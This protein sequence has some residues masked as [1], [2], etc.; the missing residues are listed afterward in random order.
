MDSAAQPPTPEDRGYP[1]TAAE[2]KE[3]SRGPRI[4]LRALLLGAL[5]IAAIFYGIDIAVKSQLP[6]VVLGAFVVWLFANV[7]LKRLWP[8]VALRRGELLTIFGMLWVAGT[9]SGSGWMAYWALILAAPAYFDSAENQWAETLFDFLP[10]HVFPETSGRVIDAFWLG[11]PQGA[12][13]PWDGW[14]GATMQWLSVSVALVAFGFCL[15]VLFQRQWEDQE[16]LA[17]PM[18]QLP[19]ELTRGVDGPG[20]MPEIFRTRLFWVGFAAAFLP[21]LYSICTYFTP[22]VP[23]LEF[24][25]Q[26]YDLELGD[27][28]PILW[29]RFLPLLMIMMYLCPLDI[30]GS[31]VAFYFFAVMKGAAMHRVGFSLGSAGHPM[32]WEKILQMESY[33]AMFFVVAWSFWLARGHLRRV[34]RQVRTGE[35]DRDEVWR[36]R[37][38]LAGLVVSG[39]YVVGWMVGLGMSLPL[40]AGVFLLTALIYFLI[41][42]LVAAT[43]FTYLLPDWD[44]M[45]GKDFILEL[46]GTV[47]LS[48]Q[49]L[50]AFSVVASHAFFGNFRVSAWPAIPHILK[51]FSMRVQPWKVAAA[52]LLAFVVGFFAAAVAALTDGYGGGM[53]RSVGAG[54]AAFDYMVELIENPRI[55][56]PERWAVWLLGFFEAMGLALLRAHFHWFPL[57]PIGLA[58]QYTPSPQRY[59][60][61]LALVWL[62]KF[63]LLRFGGVRSYNKGKLF[64]YGLGIGYVIGAMLS[65]LVD[66]VWFPLDPHTVHTW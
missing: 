43:G 9:I 22:G 56:H 10:W 26:V 6:L 30:L 46:V 40:A 53:L 36:Y 35:G 51:I 19:L 14:L 29:V 50:V 47:R 60:A 63:T 48:S 66:Y 32:G 62:A 7:A 57:H 2:A 64:F 54:I 15:I 1:E 42:K 4:T 31:L 59:W 52:V 33:G 28:F 25:W 21:I 16:R 39:L 18:A 45:K 12:P 20:R 8:A 23:P 17:F 65:D 5:T 11:L 44:H 38:A 24:Y 49:S 41:A 37:L 27:P 61:T 55:A 13:V 3:P 34:W 58:F